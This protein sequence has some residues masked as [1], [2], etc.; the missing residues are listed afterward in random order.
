MVQRLLQNLNIFYDIFEVGNISII[1][2]YKKYPSFKIIRLAFE[3]YCSLDE[4]CYE[5]VSPDVVKKIKHLILKDFIKDFSQIENFFE[6]AYFSDFAKKVLITLK[7]HVKRGKV[8][9]YKKLAE[10]AGYKNA[11]RAVGNLMAHNPYPI[12]FPCHRVIKSSMFLGSFLGANKKGIL[13]KRLLL[14]LEG[15]IFKKNDDKISSIFLTNR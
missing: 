15:I 12:L 10:C 1:L 9:T 5:K 14:E 8:I 11:F 7:N 13:L 2:I 3:N 4:L 6:T